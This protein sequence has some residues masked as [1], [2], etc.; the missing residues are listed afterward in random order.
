MN[1]LTDKAV[2]VL[3]S[4]SKLTWL[5]IDKNGISFENKAKIEA[6]IQ[7]NKLQVQKIANSLSYESETT[8]LA[9]CHSKPF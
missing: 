8:D 3:L 4:S 1:N 6:H 9:S 2:E 7:Q 5:N